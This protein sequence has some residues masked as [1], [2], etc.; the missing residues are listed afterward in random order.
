MNGDWI[1]LL[2]DFDRTI[3]GRFI[4]VDPSIKPQS[5][6]TRKTKRKKTGLRK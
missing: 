2:V 1:K 5:T 4:K 6:Y 3:G